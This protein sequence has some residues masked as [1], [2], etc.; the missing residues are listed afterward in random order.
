MFVFLLNEFLLIFS[1]TFHLLIS[2][3]L[4]VS[5]SRIGKIYVI[6]A[7]L[8]S[9]HP[10]SYKNSS[11]SNSFS[12][13]DSRPS[14]LL[15]K[16]LDHGNIKKQ[17]ILLFAYARIHKLEKNPALLTHEHVLGLVSFRKMSCNHILQKG[18]WNLTITWNVMWTIILNSLIDG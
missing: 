2:R 17:H 4:K 18:L 5:L 13:F 1:G 6:S 11:T 3:D 15:P 7:L 8:W 12:L 10:C 14:R 16:R 9:W